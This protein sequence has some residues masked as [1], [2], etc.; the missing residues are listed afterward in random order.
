VAPDDAEHE[1]VDDRRTG[2]GSRQLTAERL[3]PPVEVGVGEQEP[4][5]EDV[6]RPPQRVRQRDERAADECGDD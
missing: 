2:S 3:R 1:R 5:V 4:V 6:P